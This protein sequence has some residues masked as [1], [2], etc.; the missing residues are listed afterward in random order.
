MKRLSFLATLVVLSVFGVFAQSREI[1]SAEISKVFQHAQNMKANASFQKP[2]IN[3]PDNAGR[4]IFNSFILNYDSIDAAF[5]NANAGYENQFF[6]WQ[7]N[8]NYPNDSILFFRNVIQIYDS[9]IDVVGNKKYDRATSR[10]HVDSIL[11]PIRIVN[12]SGLNDT[13]II[14]VL[15]ADSIGIVGSGVAEDIFTPRLTWSDTIVLNQSLNLNGGFFP[16]LFKPGVSYPVGATFAVRLDFKGPQSD[17]LD[18]FGSYFTSCNDT[19]ANRSTIPY[20]TLY[21]QNLQVSPTVNISGVGPF[22]MNA[23]APC[24]ELLMQTALIMPF[25]RVETVCHSLSFTSTP[26]ACGQNNGGATV[27]VSNQTFA[28]YTYAWGGN[29]S[30]SNSISGVASGVYKVTVTGSGGC[31]TVDSVTI[32]N[33]GGPSITNTVPTHINCFGQSTG[34][35]AVTAT[36]TGLTYKWS[37]T[38]QQTAATATGLAA[39]QYTVT[40]TDGSNCISTSTVTITQPTALVGSTTKV[41]DVAC[42]G[43]TGGK[44]KVSAT[45]ATPP[46]TY[47]W[48]SSPA[49][50]T[51]SLL[52]APQGN[53]TVTITDGKGCTT[54]AGVVITEPA[55]AVTATIVNTN[56]AT[57]GQ[58]N[59]TATVSATGGTSPYTYEWSGSPKTTASVN[60]LAAASQSVTVT[61]SK[62]CTASATFTIGTGTSISDV[63]VFNKV[64]IY[65]NPAS[66]VLNIKADLNTNEA[67][68]VEMF[69]VTGK[70]VI[71]NEEAI[72]A[73]HNVT[74]NVNGLAKGVY[75]ITLKTK[76]GVSRQQVVVE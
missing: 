13:F 75:T 65:P 25:V 12:N 71:R 19:F 56:P 32:T 40:V 30:T 7:L 3:Y 45:G 37:T 42:K 69:D 10:V 74:L 5:G 26:A 53:Y 6:Y 2:T 11:I 33:T 9:L 1:S 73:N 35:A 55:T 66:S 54:T 49:Q 18:F 62:G 72:A 67:M 24:N 31:I 21:Y 58:N 47:A 17:H 38:P 39:G 50:T 68:T 48:S 76:S 63:A 52:N 43:G 27:S 15:R 23:P 64:S 60:D 16:A 41:A 14:S 59:G 61:D 22:T 57:A 4:N 36:G 20:N 34:S 28:P 70:V 51:D 29:P 46:Y 8:K 44:A